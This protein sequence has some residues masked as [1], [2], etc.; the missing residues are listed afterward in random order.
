MKDKSFTGGICVCAAS[1]NSVMRK[2]QR[3]EF[4]HDGIYAEAALVIRDEEISTGGDGEE[5]VSA[6]RS[7]GDL[8]HQKIKNG[9][10]E[11]KTPV[12]LKI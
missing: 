9:V 5:N 8:V 6:D 12:I 2:K 11:L 1:T 3:R 10:V 4:S 7:G